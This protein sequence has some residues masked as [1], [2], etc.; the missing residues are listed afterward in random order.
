MDCRVHSWNF[1]KKLLHD[2]IFNSIDVDGATTRSLTVEME[3]PKLHHGLISVPKGSKWVDG[4]WEKVFQRGYQ[5]VK[6]ANPN[7][8][9]RIRTVCTCSP[10]IFRCND[11]YTFHILSPS[12]DAIADN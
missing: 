10:T 2:L 9:K 7:F 12:N 3:G 5:Q 8:N 11:C 1:G 4:K 6:C